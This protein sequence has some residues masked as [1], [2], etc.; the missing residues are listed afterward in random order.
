MACLSFDLGFHAPCPVLAS[1]AT[2]QLLR[3]A[4]VSVPQWWCKVIKTICLREGSG[5]PSQVGSSSALH[6]CSFTAY[7]P[8]WVIEYPARHFHYSLIYY[9]LNS[10]T[11]LIYYSQCLVKKCYDKYIGHSYQEMKGFC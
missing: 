3:P 2:W 10:H 8:H 4:I 7:L 1:P 6:C 9:T 11:L 5:T